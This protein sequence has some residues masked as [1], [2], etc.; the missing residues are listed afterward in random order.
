MDFPFE[1]VERVFTPPSF[2]HHQVSKKNQKKAYQQNK[3]LPKDYNVSE[4]DELDYLVPEVLKEKEQIMIRELQKYE[5][6]AKQTQTKDQ[7][8]SGCSSSDSNQYESLGDTSDTDV[9]NG[10]YRNKDRDELAFKKYKIM[11]ECCCTDSECKSNSELTISSSSSSTYK[12]SEDGKRVKGS[13]DT[14]TDITEFHGS[15]SD[16]TTSSSDDELNVDDEIDYLENLLDEIKKAED[17][18]NG[19]DVNSD[20][21]DDELAS[22]FEESK[23]SKSSEKSVPISTP[24]STPKIK[25]K[26]RSPA[27]RSAMEPTGFPTDLSPSESSTTSISSYHSASE[28]SNISSSDPEY[29]N[30]SCNLDKF[31]W[32]SDDLYESTD[33]DSELEK[34][35]GHLGRAMAECDG[36]FSNAN[37]IGADIPLMREKF[38][39]FQQPL[40]ELLKTRVV[41]E[42][43]EEPEALKTNK[44]ILTKQLWL[45]QQLETG[46]MCS[47]K[48]V[49]RKNPEHLQLQKNLDRERK[50]LYELLPEISKPSHI[51]RLLDIGIDES[52]KFLIFE[53]LGMDLLTLFEE[54]GGLLKPS[55]IFLIT[56]FTFNAIKELH[57]FDILHCDIRP[58]SFSVT[59][60]PFNIKIVDYSRCIKKRSHMKVPED[61]Y[62]DSFSPR[63]FHRKDAEFDKFVDFESWIF[64]MIFLCTNCRLHW[65]GDHQNMLEK[66]EAF[67]ND[68]FDMIYDGCI[69]A[70]PMAATFVADYKIVYEEFLS[71]MNLIFSID[72]M[73]YPD[74]DQPQLW[75]IKELEEMRK[76]RKQN[77]SEEENIAELIESHW[78]PADESDTDDAK[79]VEVKE[80]KS[81]KGTPKKGKNDKR[82]T[83]S[84]E[85][86]SLPSPSS[87]SAM[88]EPSSN[89][90]QWSE[91]S[92]G[93]EKSK[94]EKIMTK[95]NPMPKGRGPADH[96]LLVEPLSGN[97]QFSAPLSKNAKKKDGGPL[98]KLEQ[99]KPDKPPALPKPTSPTGP[100]APPGKKNKRALLTR[101]FLLEMK[102][103]LKIAAVSSTS[104][105]SSYTSFST[106]TSS[107]C[108]TD[109]DK[110][111]KWSLK[112]EDES[113]I[114]FY[115]D[116]TNAERE[117]HRN[118]ENLRALCI[119]DNLAPSSGSEVEPF[120]DIDSDDNKA[121]LRRLERRGEEVGWE[122]VS[123][124]EKSYEAIEPEDY[125]KETRKDAKKEGEKLG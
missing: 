78:N 47:A 73:R 7:N 56:Y 106:W 46:L 112:S 99:K 102:N 77:E 11:H 59:H 18:K 76:E 118:Y 62:T 17:K 113:A 61:I 19:K 90:E 51:A 120:S 58:S 8:S 20:D 82:K 87:N 109:E 105:D 50:L 97:E 23:S 53:D 110:R 14:R 86:R 60:Y 84:R 21:S 40:P 25:S 36:P 10:F 119:Q 100:K 108:S 57:S 5:H 1:Y 29:E 80:E 12:S 121:I 24:K 52:F 94:P 115:E 63:V 68:P 85:E 88:S 81:N 39:H 93:L 111:F 66:K 96:M 95:M 45:V 2:D 114:E 89:N 41:Y 38:K 116:M 13:D 22:M 42:M 122:L 37:V 101:Q 26:E 49:S 34:V 79:S 31:K 64:T 91:A 71:K 74:S 104:S 35:L 67:F 28:S 44:D 6:L 70:I 124:K 103:D 69:E 43:L 54:F 4:E 92:S 125:I 123:E 83:P 117:R 75:T 15:S 55:V 98:P 16:E 107:T 27:E 3:L 33:T 30:S 9:V 72:V 48:L 32:E 65:F